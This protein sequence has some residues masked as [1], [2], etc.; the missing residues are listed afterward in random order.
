MTAIIMG[1]V[2]TAIVG[3]TLIGMH[4]EA[5]TDIRQFHSRTYPA[6]DNTKQSE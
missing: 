4:Y 3:R 5:R 2:L 1:L 6:N